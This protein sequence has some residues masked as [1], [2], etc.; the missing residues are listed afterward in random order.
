MRGARYAARQRAAGR[1]RSEA[2]RGAPDPRLPHRSARRL[3]DPALSS[4]TI[5][6]YDR[7][8]GDYLRFTWDHDIRENY[9]LFLGALE[10][11]GGTRILDLGCGVGRDLRQ[12]AEAGFDAVGLDGSAA[13]LAAARRLTGRPTWQQDFLD[14]KLPESEFDGVFANACLFHVPPRRLPAVLTA[15]RGTLRSSGVLFASNPT[16]S[17]EEG[18]FGGRYVCLYSQRSWCRLVRQAGFRR[19]GLLHR[20]PGLPRKQQNWLATL[21]RR[22]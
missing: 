22:V 10:E 6:H 19:I 8:A 15:I 1:D 3:R 7:H 9:A 18:W 17:D 21:W 16:G 14:L 13:M 2:R 5:A 12:F 4:A 11:V 20:P